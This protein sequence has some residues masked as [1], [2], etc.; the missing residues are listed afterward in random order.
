MY[1]FWCRSRVFLFRIQLIFFY[2]QRVM[3]WIC[4]RILSWEKWCLM[5]IHIRTYVLIQSFLGFVFVAC[6]WLFPGKISFEFLH[7]FSLIFEF[8]LLFI[9]C[10]RVLAIVCC[11]FLGQIFVYLFLLGHQIFDFTSWFARLQSIWL[12]M[13]VPTGLGLSFYGCCTFFWV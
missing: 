3:T 12:F 5:N 4:L 8:E 10:R 7:R 9:F 2:V 11:L 13:K 6:D 1:I